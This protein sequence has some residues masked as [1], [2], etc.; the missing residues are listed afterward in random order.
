MRGFNPEGNVA[1]FASILDEG[2][3]AR[4]LRQS[5]VNVVPLHELEPV[6]RGGEAAL[7]SD[8]QAGFGFVDAGEGVVTA[9]PVT[10][11]KTAG[12]DEEQNSGCPQNQLPLQDGDAPGESAIGSFGDMI[13]DALNGSGF[14]L[15]DAGLEASDF[16]IGGL[17][18]L[19]EGVDDPSACLRRHP[20]ALGGA[21]G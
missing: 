1:S 12:R 13:G 9:P 18:A 3:G 7:E 20:V 2:G 15:R 11:P 19:L 8:L 21:I 14:R 10:T 4:A 5:L 16:G 6:H 17:T